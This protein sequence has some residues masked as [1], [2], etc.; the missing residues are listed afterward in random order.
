MPP[1]KTARN[2][3][4][5]QKSHKTSRRQW[6]D[7]FA[8]SWLCTVRCCHHIVWKHLSTWCKVIFGLIICVSKAIRRSFVCL[9]AKRYL[10]QSTMSI[11][12]SSLSF[13]LFTVSPFVCWY[14]N[15]FQTLRLFLTLSLSSL[16][17][18]RQERDVLQKAEK[19][20]HLRFKS[21]MQPKLPKPVLST[22]EDHQGFDWREA[23]HQ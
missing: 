23:S 14:Y 21:A 16:I 20:T 10:L 11:E 17:V 13:E 15:A 6:W 8:S 1:F 5:T 18:D 7:E 12:C 22:Q 9:L 2:K 19:E 3:M 4:R